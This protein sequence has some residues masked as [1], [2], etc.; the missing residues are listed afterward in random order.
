MVLRLHA[1]L[2]WADP[3]IA[4]YKGG[5]QKGARIAPELTADLR[6]LSY[7]GRHPVRDR[8]GHETSR[9]SS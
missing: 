3:P 8:A 5:H 6:A 1:A 7:V 2:V 4:D 9:A